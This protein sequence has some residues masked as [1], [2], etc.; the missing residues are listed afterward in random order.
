VSAPV[1]P[2]PQA[3]PGAEQWVSGSFVTGDLIQIR[4][5]GGDVHITTCRPAYQVEPLTIGSIEL[6]VELARAQPSRLLL[7]PHEVVPFTGRRPQLAMLAG[8]VGEPGGVSLQLVHAAGGTGKTRLARQV[9]AGCAAVGWAVWQVRYAPTPV[10]GRRVAMPRRG[11][12]VVLVDYADRWPMSE[13]TA[14]VMHLRTLNLHTGV[15]VRVLLLARSAGFW[16]P[17][18][19]REL[20]EVL[21]AVG[22]AL[23]TLDDGVD[24]VALFHEAR[25]HFAAAMRV[26]GIEALPTP[27]LSG[28]AFAQIL[29]V[30]M[31]ALVTVDAHHRG[32]AAP[33]TPHALSAYLLH[34]E[35][36]HWYALHARPVDRKDTSPEVM[37]RAMYVATLVGACPRAT[38]RAALTQAGVTTPAVDTV[39][40]D[41]R[42]C[43]PP[44]DPRTVL[45]ALHPDRLG[46]DFLA[47]ATPGHPHTGD[48]GWHP[49]DWATTAAHD[50]LA[51]GQPPPVWAPAAVS[52]LVEAAHR[53]PHLAAEVLYPL[54]RQRPD[55]ALAAGGTAITRLAAIPTVDLAVL[56]AIEP[57]LPDHRHIDLDIAAMA[58]STA[59]TEHRLAAATDP[60]ERA[61]LHA[62]HAVRLGNAGHHEQALPAANAAVAAYRRLAEAD[63]TFLP[64]LAFSLNNLGVHLAELGRREEALPPAEEATAIYL[65]LAQ[66]DPT[67]FKPELARSLNNL[68]S[69]LAELGRHE[70]ALTHVER[71]TAL[72]QL[73]ASADPATFQPDLANSL[74][75]LSMLLSQVGRRRQA[76]GPAAEA[77]GIHRG[78]AQANPATYLP[79]LA[80][81]LT[82]LSKSLLE[83][84]QPEQALVHAKEATDLYRRLAQTN[85]AANL[86]HLAA[87]LGNV[88]I[89]LAQVG[90]EQQALAPTEEATDIY[91]RLAQTNPAGNLPRLAMSLN[92]LS[93]LLAQLRRQ[94]EAL[95]PA[96]EAV[97]IRRRLAA[98]NPMAFLPYLAMSLNNLDMLLLQAGQHEQ[99]LATLAEASRI[100]QRLA[101]TDPVAFLTNLGE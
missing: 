51:G 8:W 84:E 63:P 24:R 41:H 99:A 93:K 53:W 79:D 100:N 12:V 1:W 34:R 30:H 14:L 66:T 71:A 74:S 49:D 75:S 90:R 59:L 87:A 13:L 15:V 86:P 11:G 28:A 26:S 42:F 52:V 19:C 32:A 62:T 17:A 91:R 22:M 6:P 56:A 64:G 68:G 46:E 98:T 35:Q 4:D 33:S 70:A 5:V 77:V 101:R 76:P 43:Y 20:G 29:A 69:R 10:P 39:I 97:A 40:D 95:A 50:L 45:E 58:V 78:L 37:G 57:L 38:A 54:L 92:N 85:P 65:Q 67:T 94:D 72:R 9:A 81:S 18:L 61:R 73:L 89:G 31:A 16:W 48:D 47:L 25:R 55:L 60:V 44:T 2:A 83:A 23:P 82:N 3:P 27:D 80:M 96:K 36:A 7:A 88:G 21:P